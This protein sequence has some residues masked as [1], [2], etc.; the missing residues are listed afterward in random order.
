MSTRTDGIGGSGD[1]GPPRFARRVG[2]TPDTQL[3]KPAV[4]EPT[5][6]DEWF[7]AI[8]AGEVGF[9]QVQQGFLQGNFSDTVFDE[10]VPMCS[11]VPTF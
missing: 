10:L 8:R 3:E 11:D 5:T 9:A 4:R 1:S 2:L 7:T 6:P